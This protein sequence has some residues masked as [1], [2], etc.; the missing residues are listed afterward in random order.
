MFGLKVEVVDLIIVC[1]VIE[2]VDVIVEG[3]VIG[4]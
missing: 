1:G 4:C 2:I 3:V